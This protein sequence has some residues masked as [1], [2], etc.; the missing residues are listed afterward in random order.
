M[1]INTE[2]W[3]QESEWQVET[4][5]STATWQDTNLFFYLGKYADLSE[6]RTNG[7]F[8]YNTPIDYSIAYGGH[9]SDTKMPLA[10]IA[11]Y[12]YQ[13]TKKYS[14]EADN[15]WFFATQVRSSSDD[16]QWYQLLTAFE[17]GSPANLAEMSGVYR[18]SPDAINS[19][20]TYPRPYNPNR[21]I[22]P[23]VKFSPKSF[24]G[25][26]LVE[27]VKNDNSGMTTVSLKTLKNNINTYKDTYTISKAY[28]RMYGYNGRVSQD[29]NYNNYTAKSLNFMGPCMTTPIPIGSKEF[30]AYNNTM[31]QTN[32]NFPIAGTMETTHS[33]SD[34]GG[35]GHYGV[36]V[37]PLDTSNNVETMAGVVMNHLVEDTQVDYFYSRSYG[38]MYTFRVK[39]PITAEVVEE[40]YKGAAAYG[41]FF[42][43]DVNGLNV[44][45]SNVARWL[46]ENM[47]CGVLDDNGIGHGEYTKGFANASNPVFLWDSNQDSSFD[48]SKPPSPTPSSDPMLPEGLYFTM[49]GRGTGIWS[50]TPTEI[51]QV[52][53]DI[54]GSDVDV[55][56]FGN[57]PMNAILSL[58]WTPFDWTQ[59]GVID[60]GP[61]VLGDQT[62]NILHSYPMIKNTSNAEK[63]GYGTM[64]F[65]YDKNFYNAR[66]MQAR[67]F[68]PFYGYYELPAAQ[69]LSSKLRIDFYY[70]VPDELGVY[71]ISY[72]DV[73]YD[74]VECSVDLDVPL[75]GSNAAAINE[76]KR[77]QALS[78]ASQVA[79]TA[80]TSIIGA[81]T[82]AGFTGA[83]RYLASAI[84]VLA[85]ETG[86]GFSDVGLETATYF[87]GS[88]SGRAFSG[89]QAIGIGAG[90]AGAAASIANTV[91]NGKI[92]RAALK[93]NLPYHGSA[94]QT[95]FLHMSMKP[96]VQ[97]FKNAIMEG[98][99]RSGNGVDQTLGGTTEAQYKLKV[100]HACD[101]WKTINDMPEQ[102]LLQTTGVANMSSMGLELQEYQELNSIL[103]TGF[104][105]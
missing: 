60:E 61:I 54:F 66:Y 25:V 46:N 59:T 47:Y 102:S 5:L 105:R 34:S 93:T 15:G 32:A 81:S 4:N 49:A 55:K 9:A 80:A 7:V 44:D 79:A 52:W 20:D 89:S 77:S 71:I 100:G 87:G 16:F 76:S 45:T 83:G 50:L 70:N 51:D 14:L 6:Y 8:D 3:G 38:Y 28:M 94:L 73:I 26:V 63:H 65:N 1:E 85:G 90:I 24:F 21:L 10:D 96:Y 36:R 64:K 62:V 22:R 41:F 53:N 13:K 84:D 23:I 68:L 35:N 12:N 33:F 97:I 91:R 78:I 86:V 101:V 48:P 29:G 103:Q 17:T 95:T 58:K 39:I 11:I 74:Y 82:I 69:L 98:L 99:D 67:L 56:M 18:W 75:T 88:G 104:F 37:R 30:I 19:S 92:E 40:L 43:D 31:G 27:L 72:D 2:K 57:N 42:S